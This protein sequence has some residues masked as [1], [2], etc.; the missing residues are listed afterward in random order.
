M[1]SGVYVVAEVLL[2]WHNQHQHQHHRYNNDRLEHIVD[3]LICD[4]GIY[5]AYTYV[6]MIYNL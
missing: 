2:Q 4:G 5:A 6:L 1:F 3:S